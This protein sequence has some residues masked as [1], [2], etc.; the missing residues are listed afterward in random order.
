MEGDRDEKILNYED[1]MKKPTKRKKKG[2]NI[3][4][5]GKF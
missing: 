1:K 5:K 2:E 4:N 3:K